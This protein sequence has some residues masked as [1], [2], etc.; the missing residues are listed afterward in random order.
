[1]KNTDL[2]LA[3]GMIDEELLYQ[4]EHYRANFRKKIALITASVLPIAACLVTAVGLGI[5]SPKGASEAPE[6]EAPAQMEETIES[7]ILEDTEEEVT[8]Q[9]ESFE[10]T[11]EEEFADEENAETSEMAPNFTIN[12]RT[13]MISP[14]LAMSETLPEGFSYAGDVYVGGFDEKLPCYTNENTPEWVYVY[15]EV[16]TNGTVD[17]HGTLNRTEPHMAYV[18]Y[19]VLE[20]RGK[21]LIMVDGK[22][23][24]SLWTAGN[25]PYYEEKYGVR[26][27]E[28]PK[29]ARYIGN[30]VFC[31]KD[32]I[33][34][35][36]L[37]ANF[38]PLE[39]YL[40]DEVLYVGA[41]WFTWTAEEDSET[42]HFGYDIF[43][44]YEGNF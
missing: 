29:D 17:E 6:A 21:S 37:E 34:K 31:G 39:V 13:Y 4:A 19:V 41:S 40:A 16:T 2:F 44:P 38:E 23:Y 27:T 8:I 18:R 33:P 1:M 15:Q 26:T 9:E 36:D 32:S 3:I 20:L 24:V 43:I 11:P 5:F 28:K 10:E 42:Q 12:G 35:K 7:G 30:S 22:L 25:A 14:S